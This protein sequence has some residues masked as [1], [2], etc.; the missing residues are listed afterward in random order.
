MWSSHRQHRINQTINLLIRVFRLIRW[1]RRK[2][3]SD[4]NYHRISSLQHLKF[5]LWFGCMEPVWTLHL[6]SCRPCTLQRAKKNGECPLTSETSLQQK[7]KKVCL[8]GFIITIPRTGFTPPHPTTLRTCLASNCLCK[9]LL[10]TS[11]AD[12]FWNNGTI[13]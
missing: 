12:L 6:P 11:H 2:F 10:P 3:F 9:G 5:W 7:R 8:I 13:R 1:K 4:G